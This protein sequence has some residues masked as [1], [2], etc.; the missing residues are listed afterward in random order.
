MNCLQNKKKIM[1]SVYLK[2]SVSRN[3]F[4]L[5]QKTFFFK[6]SFCNL[7]YPTPPGET[8]RHLFA[9][10]SK[11]LTN[12]NS[13]NI[14]HFLS[15]H[16]QT[17]TKFHNNASKSLK[18]TAL[19]HETPVPGATPPRHPGCRHDQAVLSGLSQGR[20]INMSIFLNLAN[21]PGNDI[22]KTC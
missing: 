10:N 9:R 21:I 11:Y 6:S 7:K 3:Y 19:S 17:T 1:H 16:E 22:K 20:A 14:F 5:G 2:K 15:H 4:I 8:Q 12:K 18:Q 13:L